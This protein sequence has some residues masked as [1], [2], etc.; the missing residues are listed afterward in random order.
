MIIQFSSIDF[1]GTLS[2]LIVCLTHLTLLTYPVPRYQIPL[3]LPQP[4]QS[5]QKRMEWGRGGDSAP[6][7]IPDI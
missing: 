2:L 3:P 5:Q 1:T 6:L 7:P 4:L